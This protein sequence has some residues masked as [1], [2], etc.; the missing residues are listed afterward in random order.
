M[1][2]AAP[3]N[4]GAH[5]GRCGWSHSSRTSEKVSPRSSLRHSEVGSQ[6]AQT[7][8]GRSAVSGWICQTR[9][10]AVSV[11]AG[12]EMAAFSVSCHV[13]PRSSDHAMV[14]PQ[15]HDMTPT[16]MRGVA[17]RVSIA[18]EATSCMRKCGPSTVQ[19]R[20]SSDR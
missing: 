14:G 11:S 17:R 1:C 9:P 8:S 13:A 10:S 16:M 3:P 4:P 20:R 15:C 18:T 12:K 6:P 19:V 5:S 2:T 7:T